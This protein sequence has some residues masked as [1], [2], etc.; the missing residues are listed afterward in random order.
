M[1][2]ERKIAH[3]MQQ[4]EFMTTKGFERDDSERDMREREYNR[5][6]EQER[7]DQFI[8]LLNAWEK[9]AELME[10]DQDQVTADKII[11]K[12]EESEKSNFSSFNFVNIQNNEI[13]KLRDELINYNSAED[14]FKNQYEKITQNFENDCA[15][16]KDKIADMDV[17]AMEHEN[18]ISETSNRIDK[19]SNAVVELFNWK[20][21]KD[22]FKLFVQ[23]NNIF[24]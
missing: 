13:E 22:N 20:D 21:F 18:K 23:R 9:I 4:N 10:V 12:F 8:N 24:F 15:D 16:I 17:T 2:E 1:S 14:V 11:H 3:E 5:K 19:I 6:R 7:E